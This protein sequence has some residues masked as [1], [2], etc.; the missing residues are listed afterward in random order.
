[1]PR[2]VPLTPEQLEKAAAVY[3]QTGNYSEAGRAIGVEPQTARVALLRF[4]E[5]KRS[6]L[7]TRAIE[8][9][10]Q[11]GRKRLYE[12]L[13]HGSRFLDAVDGK[14]YAAVVGAIARGTEALLKLDERSRETSQSRL[15]RDK[16]RAE[17]TLLKA[18]AQG[19]LPP[20]VTVNV[21]DPRA[22][23]ELVRK[24][25]GQSGAKHDVASVDERRDPGG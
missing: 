3:K 10:L 25:F 21:T 2:G 15:T 5:V 11:L 9:G 22:V 17:I 16:T 19:D 18:K 6:Q 20:D 7:N 8:K 1:M 12:A 4:G 24:H 13:E 14:E 23:D